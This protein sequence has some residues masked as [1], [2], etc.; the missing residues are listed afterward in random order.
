M[1]GSLAVARVSER[2]AYFPARP[3]TPS[4]FSAFNFSIG[5]CALRPIR[6]V[7]RYRQAAACPRAAQKTQAYRS[8]RF[9]AV[10]ALVPSAGTI[11]LHIEL[12]SDAG[13]VSICSGACPRAACGSHALIKKHK[14]CEFL[15]FCKRVV[16]RS[17]VEVLRQRFTPGHQIRPRSDRLCR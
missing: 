10:A 2:G 15:Q 1:R 4:R 5:H 11:T 7:I 8:L 3:L 12:R 6:H 17:S 9:H 16:D 13:V 14:P